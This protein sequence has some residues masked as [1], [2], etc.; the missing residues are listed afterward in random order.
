MKTYKLVWALFR[1]GLF[2]DINKIG[3]E[4][5]Y[6]KCVQATMG[7]AWNNLRPRFIELVNAK[8]SLDPQKFA[9]QMLPY[10][11]TLAPIDVDNP[12][13]D[14]VVFTSEQLIARNEQADVDFKKYDDAMIALQKRNE[15]IPPHMLPNT[16][17]PQSPAEKRRIVDDVVRTLT[18]Q[19]AVT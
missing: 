9:P 7:D 8:P 6:D 3:V 18:D 2:R 16:I 11:P 12:Q 13:F 1:R 5:V 17:I 15:K 14:S 19:M 10:V 4:I